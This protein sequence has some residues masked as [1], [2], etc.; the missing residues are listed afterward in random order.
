MRHGRACTRNSESGAVRL[1]VTVLAASSATT[2]PSSVQVAG[3]FRQASA[4][5]MT[6]KKEPEVGLETLKM[7][8]KEATTSSTSRS[9]PSENLMPLRSLKV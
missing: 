2:P 5:T 4:P 8:W 1:M 6:L 7:R 9:L 3:V